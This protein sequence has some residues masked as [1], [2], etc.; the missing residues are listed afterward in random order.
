MQP[1]QELLSQSTLPAFQQLTTDNR[2]VAT[3]PTVAGGTVGP[4]FA[5]GTG[6]STVENGATVESF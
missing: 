1:Q 4:L 3:V 2:A 6:G 5:S